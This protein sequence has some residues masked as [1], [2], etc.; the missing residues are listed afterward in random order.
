M[1]RANMQDIVK[2]AQ[3]VASNIAQNNDS[4]NDSQI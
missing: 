3:Q 2:M 4:N 1:E